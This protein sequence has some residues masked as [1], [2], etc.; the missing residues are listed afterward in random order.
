M[1]RSIAPITCL[2]LELRIPAHYH[3]E[4]ILSYLVSQYKLTINIIAANLQAQTQKQGY[5]VIELQGSP[6]QLNKALSY[7]RSLQMEIIGK[8]NAFGDCWSY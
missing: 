1:A 3:Q 6:S 2:R 7:L 8:P 4:P 5:L